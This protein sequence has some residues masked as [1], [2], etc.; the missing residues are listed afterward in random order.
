[1]EL[2]WKLQRHE[3]RAAFAFFLSTLA[4]SARAQGN[5]TITF[6]SARNIRHLTG[7]VTYTDG[8]AVP[9][10]VVVDCDSSYNR[11]LTSTKTDASGHF[12]LPHAKLGSKHYLKIDFP[13]FQEVHMPVRICPL[14]KAGLRIWLTPG[15]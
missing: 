5:E 4:I 8:A 12:S 3:Y 9:G 6:K 7:V 2:G 1:M 10:A 11:V 14:A 13:A 15:T